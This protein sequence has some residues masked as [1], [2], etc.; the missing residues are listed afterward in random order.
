MNDNEDQSPFRRGF[1][2][3]S[4]VI[5]AVLLCGALLLITGLTTDS[6]GTANAADPARSGSEAGQ[7]VGAHPATPDPGERPGT[8]DR[9]A[10]PCS[11]AESATTCPGT[12]PATPADEPGSG[13]SGRTTR[14]ASA[15]GCSLP[16]GDQAVP[17]KAPRADGWDVS[18]H[19]VVPRSSIFGPAVT[20]PDGFRRCFAHSPTGA[21]YA[22]YNTIAAVNDP[23]QA[24]KTVRKLMVPGPDTE[25]LI[26]ELESEND[27]PGSA[28]TAQI[29]GFSVLDSRPDRVTVMLAL[30]VESAYMSATFTLVWHNDDWRLRPPSPGQPVGAPFAQ[31][32]DLSDFTRWSGI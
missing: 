7:P 1:V 29:A 30:P 10:T 32:R 28:S 22:A 23:R 3:A 21:V 6:S 13:S 14:P 31:H 18:R 11:D 5:A 27:V 15:G 4:I 26:R 20:D 24:I 12:Q 16:A 19:V 8:G 25:A 17:T 2:A 9:A